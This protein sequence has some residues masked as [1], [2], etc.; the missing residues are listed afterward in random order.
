MRIEFKK[1]EW[2]F[3]VNDTNVIVRWT[4]KGK[5]QV[6]WQNCKQYEVSC[7]VYNDGSGLLNKVCDLK[8]TTALQPNYGNSIEYLKRILSEE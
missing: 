8:I 1:S 5:A 7:I 2:T 3:G 4:Y 6:G